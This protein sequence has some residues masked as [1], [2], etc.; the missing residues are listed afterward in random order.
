MNTQ[1]CDSGHCFGAQL[2]AT[3]RGARQARQLAVEKIAEWGLPTEGPA[4][5][6]AELAANAVSHGR[7]PGRDFRIVLTL[8]DGVLRIEVADTRGDR[9][10]RIR[11]AEGGAEGG[12]G[13]VLV[14]ALAD[15]WGVRQGPVPCKVVWAEVFLA[16]GSRGAVLRRA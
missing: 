1:I 4:L 15:R 10:P 16:T 11:D 3:P 7:V 9:I 5:I 2:A 14:D 6:V 13:L 12:R 8:A